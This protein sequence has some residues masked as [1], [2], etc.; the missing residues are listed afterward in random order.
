MIPVKNVTNMTIQ[1]YSELHVFLI[2]VE[3]MNTLNI[4]RFHVKHVVNI[5]YFIKMGKDAQ[6]V[7]V[8]HKKSLSQILHVKN[9]LSI[10]AQLSKVNK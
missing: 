2:T 6:Q 8:L 10:K 3:A 4:H 5:H 7:N 9:V 1:M